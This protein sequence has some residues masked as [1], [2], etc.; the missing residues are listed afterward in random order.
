MCQEMARLHIL[1]QSFWVNVTCQANIS[2]YMYSVRNSQKYLLVICRFGQ[3]K[4]KFSPKK[5]FGCPIKA[6]KRACPPCLRDG[7]DDQ[8]SGGHSRPPEAL[9]Y[10]INFRFSKLLKF[11]TGAKKPLA[12]KYK[13]NCKNIYFWE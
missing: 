3:P 12:K 7:P 1:I 2:V 8:G 11:E 9:G 5:V 10:F 4:S 6:A 13:N